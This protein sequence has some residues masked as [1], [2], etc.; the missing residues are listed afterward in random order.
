[1]KATIALLAAA[2]SLAAADPALLR[3]VPADATFVAGFNADKMKNSPIARRMLTRAKA[4][5]QDY[6]KLVED[7]GFDPERD[8][9]EV[10]FATASV[11]GSNGLL[12]ATGAFDP[13]RFKVDPK[14]RIVLLNASLLVMGDEKDVAAALERVQSGARAP[15]DLEARVQDISSRYDAWLVT[16]ESPSK[17]LAGQIPNQTLDAAI[18][19]DLFQSIRSMT[20]GIRSTDD[21]ELSGEAV[22]RSEKDASALVDVARFFLTMIG[23]GLKDKKLTETSTFQAEGSTVRFSLTVPGPLLERLIRQARPSAAK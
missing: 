8:L 18:K 5:G 14:R 9:R 17:T 1:M 10:L 3:L 13:A 20:V 4:E 22:A 15:A 23:D 7:S 11:E 6:R 21:L 19:G 2:F 16:T 12:A